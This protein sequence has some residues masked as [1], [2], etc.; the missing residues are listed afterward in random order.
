VNWPNKILGKH[1]YLFYDCVDFF[2]L[3]NEQE[4]IVLR[5]N[6]DQL[7]KAAD[8]MTVNS[9]HLQ[10]KYLPKRDSIGLI[11]TGFRYHHFK[12][13]KDFARNS[14]THHATVV[15][16]GAIN[17]RLNFLLLTS[18]I[19]NASHITFVFVGPIYTET[20][21]GTQDIRAA[22]AKL[23]K[24]TNF[25]HIDY[26]KPNELPPLLIKAQV[27]IIPYDLAI[28]L[29]YNCNPI[30]LLEYYY[31]GL[32]VLSVNI[33]SLEAF[34][35]RTLKIGKTPSEWV[36]HLEYLLKQPPTLKEQH[37]LRKRAIENSWE[38]RIAKI[39]EY[40]QQLEK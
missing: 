21:G 39:Y 5:K 7:L 37:Q 31:F 14:K 34:A 33:P 38:N 15:Y 20:D 8:L 6:E 19:K 40:I 2:T 30:K 18:L 28:D 24:F 17:Y 4:E 22:F 23:K 25:V 29:N 3:N 32:P 26:V 35:S 13:F 10:N 11:P 27:G 1:S 9:V 36:Q 12:K 16:V